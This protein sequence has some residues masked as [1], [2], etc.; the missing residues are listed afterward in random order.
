MWSHSVV[1][2]IKRPEWRLT[3]GY[4]ADADHPSRWVLGVSASRVASFHI[5]DDTFIVADPSV[6]AELVTDPARITL[7]WPHMNLVVTKDRKA[8]GRHWQVDGR[9]A[10]V[11]W[12]GSM[13]MWLEPKL[14]GVIVHHYVRWDSVGRAPD[15]RKMSRLARRYATWWKGQVLALKD[16]VEFGRTLGVGRFPQLHAR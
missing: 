13:E 1:S 9:W 15:H 6:M 5:A 12:T 4:P 8:L 3:I 2:L 14:D 16:E 7:W 10:N 11:E